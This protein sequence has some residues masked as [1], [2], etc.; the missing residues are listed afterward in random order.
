MCDVLKKA[1]A[2]LNSKLLQKTVPACH[3]TAE[4]TLSDREHISCAPL[5]AVAFEP[6][7]WIHDVNDIHTIKNSKCR[8]SST[9][10]NLLVASQRVRVRHQNF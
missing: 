10:V 3:A 6:S 5:D 8:F 2:E 9:A 7:Y 1:T 4:P